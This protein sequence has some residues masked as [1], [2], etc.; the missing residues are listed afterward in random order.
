V[1][2]ERFEESIRN[3]TYR[4]PGPTVVQLLPTET[5]N[6]RC[7]MCNQWG[8]NSYFEAGSRHA[9]HMDEGC[10]TSLLRSLK[11]QDVFISIHGGEPFAYKHTDTL[12]SLLAE[13]QFDVVF[14]TNGTLLLKHLDRLAKIRN[15][16]LLLSID[17]D[18]S[19]HNKIR[20]EGRFAETRDAIT[21]LFELRRAQRIPLPLVMMNFVVCEWNSDSLYKMID[22]AREF[23]AFSLNYNMRWFLTDEVGE[24]Y[25]KHILR[26]FGV[27]SSGAWRGWI[28]NHPEHDNSGAAQA[29]KGITSRRRFRPPFVVTTPS[30]LR[31]DDFK[32]YFTDYLN[33]FGNESCFMPFYWAR[34]HSNGDLIYCPGHPDIIAG[35]VFEEGLFNAFNSESSVKFRKHI[36]HNR[37]PICNRCCGLYMTN[38]ARPYEQKARKNLGLGKN[39]QVHFP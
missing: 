27:H 8:E 25:E 12:L 9:E 30:Q 7:P 24:A 19:T 11:P 38:P 16:G 37:F 18:E 3:G 21:A 2:G 34:I 31:G 36:L 5:C 26:E 4:L 20:G 10:L 32:E 14:T 33:V 29:L 1:W 39:V 22:V 28:S 15:L 35:N 6:L 13:Q 17:G 23:H